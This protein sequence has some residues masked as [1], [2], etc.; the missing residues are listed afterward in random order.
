MRV[1]RRG[2]AERNKMLDEGK[3]YSV[4]VISAAA[5]DRRR[6]GRGKAPPLSEEEEE[7]TFEKIV[8][9]LRVAKIHRQQAIVLGAFGCGVS[10]PP[11]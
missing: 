2:D 10:C 5:L 3:R 4:N 11:D 9:V 1:F 7:T 8:T 6:F